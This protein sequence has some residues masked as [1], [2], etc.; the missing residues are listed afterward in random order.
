MA[1][2]DSYL[3]T[4]DDIPVHGPYPIREVAGLVPDNWTT[5]SYPAATETARTADF[6]LEGAGEPATLT[7][8]SNGNAKLAVNL[9][10]MSFYLVCGH[11]D[12]NGPGGTPG[13]AAVGGIERM[14]G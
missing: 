2:P 1:V 9:P 6:Y 11:A 7:I 3:S 5:G 14:R 12:R 10:P 8:D 4:L 13:Q